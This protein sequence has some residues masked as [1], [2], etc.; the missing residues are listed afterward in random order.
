MAR[1]YLAPTIQALPLIYSVDSPVGQ[2]HTNKRDDVLLVQFFLKVISEH[3][4]LYMPPGQSPIQIDG[5]HGPQTSAYIRQY[6]LENSRRNPGAKAGGTLK[7]DG[8]VHPIQ[9]GSPVS[10]VS[11]T[12]YTIV[13]LN[14]SY[15]RAR[16]TEMLRD[17]TKDPLFPAGLRPSIAVG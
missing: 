14:L 5:I 3:D 13:A 9:A 10:P 16:G 4:R 17:I 12:L 8:I 11:S 1:V 15:G 6:Q 2:N 7:Q